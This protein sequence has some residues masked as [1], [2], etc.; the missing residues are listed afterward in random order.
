MGKPGVSLTN[1]T[2]GTEVYNAMVPDAIGQALDEWRW[3]TA[4]AVC[5]VLMG[6]ADGQDSG[7][8][9]DL[10]GELLEGS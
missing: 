5:R 7:R 2:T 6:D 9:Y 4:D 8:L 10:L 1:I 3:T